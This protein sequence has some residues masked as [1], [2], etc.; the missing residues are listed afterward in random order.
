MWSWGCCGSHWIVIRYFL[1]RWVTTVN[2]TTT[3]QFLN[4]YISLKTVYFVMVL[5]TC[6]FISN[7]N[8]DHL[9]FF[10]CIKQT[11]TSFQASHHLASRN[12][13]FEV[14]LIALCKVVFQKINISQQKTTLQKIRALFLMTY[15]SKINCCKL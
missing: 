14:W 11:R 5:K 7:F 10:S 4:V 9:S 6:C 15:I 8:V 12:Q 1:W 13:V 2:S 3:N